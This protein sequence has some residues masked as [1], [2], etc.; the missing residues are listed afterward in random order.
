M[1]IVAI[2]LAAILACMI[3]GGIVF[4]RMRADSIRRQNEMQYQDSL[5]KLAEGIA[6]TN[7]KL[8]GGDC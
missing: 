4:A 7:I 3:T 5:G 2:L 8:Q 1:R 6:C